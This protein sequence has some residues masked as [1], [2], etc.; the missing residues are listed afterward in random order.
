MRTLAEVARNL[1]NAMASNMKFESFFSSNNKDVD[2]A[3]LD[4]VLSGID[5]NRFKVQLLTNKEK[6]L[7]NKLVNS[8]KEV[9]LNVVQK[10]IGKDRA[11]EIHWASISLNLKERDSAR[12]RRRVELINLGK[13]KEPFILEDGKINIIDIHGMNSEDNQ[14]DIRLSLPEELDK[15]I[16]QVGY[17]EQASSDAEDVV[18]DESGIIKMTDSSGKINSSYLS[19]NFKSHDKSSFIMTGG[20]LRGCFLEALNGVVKEAVKIESSKVDF[21]IPIDKCY[22]DP[23]Y[24]KITNY[25]NLSDAILKTINNPSEIYEDGKLVAATGTDKDLNSKFRFYIWKKTSLMIGNMMAQFENKKN[26]SEMEN[27]R[28]EQKIKDDEEL[29]RVRDSL[30]F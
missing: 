20:N 3:K 15:N 17:S 28:Q 11:R 26:N 9:D 13:D 4:S 1:R 14:N 18:F 2:N 6:N 25:E 5:C 21:H 23:I 24:N 27:M 19:E 29:L 8:G 22:D 7:I 16:I 12:E 30:K 10:V